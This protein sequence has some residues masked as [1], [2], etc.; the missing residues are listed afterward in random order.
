MLKF[1]T[2]AE[3]A[4]LIP[5]YIAVPHGKQTQSASTSAG[6]WIVR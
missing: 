6:T 4:Y 3:K 5:E 2:A 1:R